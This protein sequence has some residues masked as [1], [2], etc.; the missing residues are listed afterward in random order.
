[1]ATFCLLQLSSPTWASLPKS[2]ERASWMGPGDPI[3]ANWKYVRPEFVLC[4]SLRSY[5]PNNPNLP[6]LVY[7]LPLQPE[8]QACRNMHATCPW[9]SLTTQAHQFPKHAMS[10]ECKRHPRPGGLKYIHSPMEVL[11]ST[12]FLSR[13]SEHNSHGTLR[14]IPNSIHDY[15]PIMQTAFCIVIAKF[16]QIRS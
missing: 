4:V 14:C 2:T 5:E 12:D 6:V 13:K 1:M 11:R 7:V 16:S 3:W 15:S 10:M 8:Q 9:Y